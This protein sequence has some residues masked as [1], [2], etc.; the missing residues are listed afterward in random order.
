MTFF[1]YRKVEKIDPT[2]KVLSSLRE[3]LDPLESERDETPQIAGLKRIL[4]W[5][6]AEMECKT[7]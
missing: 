1:E 4:A 2:R 6:I 7:A 3:S 5:R